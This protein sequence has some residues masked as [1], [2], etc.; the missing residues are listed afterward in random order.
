MIQTSESIL[1]IYKLRFTVF[2]PDKELLL[3]D[4]VLDS[5]KL[6]VALQPLFEKGYLFIF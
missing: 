3:D 6:N 5:D 2:Q 1:P 4:F